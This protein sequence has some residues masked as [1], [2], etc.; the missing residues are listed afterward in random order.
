MWCTQ[1]EQLHLHCGEMW[2]PGGENLKDERAEILGGKLV[3]KMISLYLSSHLDL[4]NLSLVLEI[5]A[6]LAFLT[7]RPVTSFV[8]ATPSRT[9]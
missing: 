5:A 9:R 2:V 4:V 3:S 7:F 6:M 8:A 1:M